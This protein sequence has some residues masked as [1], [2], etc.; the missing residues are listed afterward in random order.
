MLTYDDGLKVKADIAELNF[1]ESY[2]ELTDNDAEIL[3][4]KELDVNGE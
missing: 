3:Y 1:E 4:F 2:F